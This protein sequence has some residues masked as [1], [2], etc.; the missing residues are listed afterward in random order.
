MVARGHDAEELVEALRKVLREPHEVGEGGRRFGGAELSRV[1]GVPAVVFDAGRIQQL[2]ESG[3]PAAAA[4]K[5]PP[6]N[7]DYG[8]W[9]DLGRATGVVWA[10]SS[11][12]YQSV[13][14]AALACK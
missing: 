6:A 5:V 9:I 12:R 8:W 13:Y 1:R 2:S 3:D 7:A 11:E 14:F 4:L 10:E